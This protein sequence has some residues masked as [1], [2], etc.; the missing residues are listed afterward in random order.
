MIKSN[1]SKLAELEALLFYNGEPM[2]I[3]KIASI[4]VLKED[5]VSNLIDELKTKLESDS[6]SGIFVLTKGRQVQLATKPE[7]N[8]ILQKLVENELKEQL[9]PATL[10]TVSIISYLGPITRSQIDYIRG[11]NSSFI[12]RNLILRGLIERKIG[13]AKGNVY[14]YEVSL[15]FIKHMG[16]K[17]IEELPEYEKYK[18]IL[19][20]LETQ[21]LLHNNS[22]INES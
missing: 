12:L 7:F 21:D 8:F 10:E 22:I 13:R 16:I 1:L 4:L 18:N 20:R 19:Q 2:D 11:V 9:T 6:S 5:E 3:Q 17:K 15:N 14:E